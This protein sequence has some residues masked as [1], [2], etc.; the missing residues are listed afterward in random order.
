[1]KELNL[2]LI[3]VLNLNTIVRPVTRTC[4]CIIVKDHIKI[5]VANSKRVILFV[6]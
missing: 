2:Y 5:V 3:H 4:I 1:M 6:R